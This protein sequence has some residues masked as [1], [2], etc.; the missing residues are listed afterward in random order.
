MQ[1]ATVMAATNM[2]RESKEKLSN[3]E[4]PKKKTNKEDATNR[5]RKKISTAC[6]WSFSST[7]LCK[8]TECEHARSK[9][10]SRR[11]GRASGR[12]LEH[13]SARASWHRS[14]CGEAG[15][16]AN[17][18]TTKKLGSHQANLSEGWLHQCIVVVQQSMMS[19]WH[20]DT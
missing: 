17:G 6:T 16:M 2:V 7:S 9:G 10:H 20:G 4:W 1:H 11:R 12:T 19:E 5:K 13:G 18:K 3:D 14:D 8:S 15:E